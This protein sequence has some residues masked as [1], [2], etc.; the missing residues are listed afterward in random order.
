MWSRRHGGG[1]AAMSQVYILV[2]LVCI[3]G[4]YAL[5]CAD[6]PTWIT[7]VIYVAIA[8]A[9]AV[10]IRV[11]RRRYRPGVRAGWWWL[12]VGQTVFVAA[13]ACD[14]GQDLLGA[15]SSEPSAADVLYIAAYPL[16]AIGLFVF[17]RRR[18]PGWNLPSLLD[19]AI[20]AVAAGLLSWIYLVAPFTGN[21][22]M[23]IA[24][25]V[26]QGTYPLMDL[27]LLVLAARLVLGAGKRSV[28]LVL[29]LAAIVLLLAGDTGYAVANL[30]G[31][32]TS[33]GVGTLGWLGCYTLL[34]CAGL[35]PS[36]AQLDERCTVA[37][38]DA[39]FGRL[40]ILT[41]AIIA[42]PAVQVVQVLRGDDPHVLLAAGTCVVMLILVLARMAGVVA[43]QR[44]TATTDALTGLKTR[45]YLE[46]RLATEGR[47]TAG[48]RHSAGLLIVDVDHFKRVNDTFGHPG[49][50]QVLVEVARRLS[51]GAPRGAVVAR[52]GGEEFAVLL[53]A[54]DADSVAA[55]AE[56][57]RRVIAEH[58]F[59]VA[60]TSVV[61][62]ASVGG[63]C[64]TDEVPNA[65][66]LVISADRALYTA[67]NAG[68][69]RAV[70]HS[71]LGSDEHPL[72]RFG[73]QERLAPPTLLSA[74]R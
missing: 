57:A 8:A 41:M 73:S 50:D 38:P 26:V 58:P 70:M 23:S 24:A 68:R 46:Q 1:V 60:G 22:S 56:T 7:A 32:E 15:G 2:N 35:H 11:G 44:V 3:A 53:P 74:E 37:A 4:F 48:V 64:L 33:A 40:F 65:E 34:G 55:T 71:S 21:D 5:S 29:V 72:V 54:G 45:R 18:T 10:A 20:I 67:K 42:A 9:A 43:A 25:K 16:F 19:A 28:A 49:G 13:E 59:E 69:N 12:A 51:T 27:V 17:V 30:L 66:V 63:S 62:T 6:A 61:V 31:A 39:G 47:R 36:M 52:Y 14:W